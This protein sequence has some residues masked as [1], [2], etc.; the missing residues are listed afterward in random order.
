MS[1]ELHRS[2]RSSEKVAPTGI[3]R[4]EGGK[5]L[6]DSSTFRYIDPAK[7]N[8][9]MRFKALIIS[10]ALVSTT[11][12]APQAASAA[13]AVV[14]SAKP[15]VAT[16]S[17]ARPTQNSTVVVAVSKV[18]VGAAVTTVAHYK[19]TNT[20]KRATAGSRGTASLPYLISRA[21]HGFRV[22]ITVTAAKGSARWSCNTAFIT[23]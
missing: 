1:R 13:S 23:R 16:V 3:E 6:V 2:P 14:A 5:C 20:T 11:V 9:S 22:V 8:S 21:T 17:N 12:V 4:R 15:C 19:S 7:G 18:A 10:M